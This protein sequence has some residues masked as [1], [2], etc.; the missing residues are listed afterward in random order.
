MLFTNH[1]H[2]PDSLQRRLDAQH[3]GFYLF[4]GAANVY[5]TRQRKNKGHR[6]TK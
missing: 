2:S 3:Q 6:R 5:A 4:Y 1:K